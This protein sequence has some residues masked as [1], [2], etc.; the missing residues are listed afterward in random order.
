MT[1][2]NLV[3]I[4]HVAFNEDITRY[5]VQTSEGGSGYYAAAGAVAAG[6]TDIG[7]VAT[8]GTDFPIEKLDEMGIHMEGI[9]ISA[10]PTARFVI[11]QLSDT[12]R[13]FTARWG[14][15]AGKL[16]HLPASFRNAPVIHLATA[17]PQ[18]QIEW[19]KYLRIVSP[20]SMIAVDCFEHFAEH[21]RAATL[22]AMEMADFIF[23]NV[24][25][26]RILDIST[27]ELSAKPYILKAGPYGASLGLGKESYLIRAPT[28]KAI[29]TTGAGDVLAGAFLS[30]YT[31]DHHQEALS[32]AIRIASW[33]VSA[34]GVN[35]LLTHQ[36]EK[37]NIAI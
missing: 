37:R 15:A 19:I 28:V 36:Y 23:L 24:A 9:S 31:K 25:E 1:T 26:L 13:R 20:Q 30:Q 34:F 8:I 2:P 32:S 21:Y 10:L 18:E 3:I 5:G 35:H 14:A 29:D 11:D 33:S 17:P 27:E 4:G 6:R 16:R 7:L 12:E 22:E